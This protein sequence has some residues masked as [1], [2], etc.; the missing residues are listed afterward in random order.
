LKPAWANSSRDP[1]WKIS[2][3]HKK[4]AGGMVQDI[5]SEL[6]PPV[7]KEKKTKKNLA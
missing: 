6:K 1:T 4:W 2:N 5:G 7:L 3:T